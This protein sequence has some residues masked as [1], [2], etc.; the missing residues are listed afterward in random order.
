[1]Q[2]YPFVKLIANK[3]NVGFSKANNQGYEIAKGEYILLLNPDAKLIDNTISRAI[4]YLEQFPKSL[5]APRL[6]N[7][8]GT[9]Q[10]SIIPVA[11]PFSILSEA[12]FL[13]YFLKKNQEDVYKS[14][15]YGFSGACLLMKN[16]L[17]QH[18]NGLDI[19]LFWMED[20]DFCLRA[21]ALGYKLVYLKDWEV[22]HHIGQSSKKNY[23]IAITNQL[24]S[25][26]KF[27]KK[28]QKSIS[29]FIAAIFLE[30]HILSRIFLFLVLSP[31]KEQFKL[32]LFAYFY[33]HSAFTKYLLNHKN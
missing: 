14:G 24:I 8:D 16:E 12:F 6:L 17:Y 23:K 10:E 31:F 4:K 13:G 29:A 15:E 5:L 26:H 25:K 30:L 22:V 18:L 3:G 33:A 7:T 20:I 1:M 27:L 21:K 19:D 32:K 2:L 28:Q 9:I 11:S